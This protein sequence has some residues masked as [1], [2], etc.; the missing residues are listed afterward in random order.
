MA[1]CWE[2]L[3][4][5]REAAEISNNR[6]QRFIDE[7]LPDAPD[8][9]AF[10]E[11]KDDPASIKRLQ[12]MDRLDPYFEDLFQSDRFTGLASFLLA[13]DVVPKAPQWF[14]KPA[15]VGRS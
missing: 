13:D 5:F 9:T 8:T 3:P 15:R 10:Y 4:V 11:D 12:Y 6:I 2:R 1:S 7:V 14:N